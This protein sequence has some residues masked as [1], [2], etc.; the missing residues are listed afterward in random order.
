MTGRGKGGKGLGFRGAKSRCCRVL[1]RGAIFDMSRND[2]RRMARR[3]GV[4]RNSG[5]MYEETRGVLTEFLSGVVRDATLYTKH[6]WKN[7]VTAEAVRHA[8]RSHTGRVLY[9][10]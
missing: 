9:H 4:K 2:I 10:C 7:T 3:G 8:L 5:L 6:Q 1:R